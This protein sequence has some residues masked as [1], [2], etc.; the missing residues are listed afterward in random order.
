VDEVNINAPK[1][2]IDIDDKRNRPIT[3]PKEDNITAFKLQPI[4]LAKARKTAGPG[5]I[6]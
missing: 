3:F 4:P 1:P 5:L 2:I 6:M